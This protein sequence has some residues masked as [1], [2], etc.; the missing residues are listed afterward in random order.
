MDLTLAGNAARKW[1]A[2]K[3]QVQPNLQHADFLAARV[4]IIGGFAGGF[5]AGTHQDHH[6]LGVRIAEVVEQVVARPV[7]PANLS[8]AACTIPGTLA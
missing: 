8:I 7:M 3:G 2:D 6:P 5:R 1:L 4:Q